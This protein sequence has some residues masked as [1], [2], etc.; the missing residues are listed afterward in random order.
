MILL[1]TGPRPIVEE[2]TVCIDSYIMNLR[3]I[4][5]TSQQYQVEQQPSKHLRLRTGQKVK[6]PFSIAEVAAGGFL[7]LRTSGNLEVVPKSPSRPPLLLDLGGEV[8][9]FSHETSAK[10]R[11]YTNV[12]VLTSNDQD[13]VNLYVWTK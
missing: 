2:M 7:V 8:L 10:G 1:G 5:K 12:A 6:N 13:P 11:A 9:C 3:V 4:R